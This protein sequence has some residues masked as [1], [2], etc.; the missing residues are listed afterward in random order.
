MVMRYNEPL[1]RPPAEANSLI[2]Q[3]A[4]ECPNNTCTFCGM[5]KGKKYRERDPIDTKTVETYQANIK[6]KLG[7]ENASELSRY[8]IQWVQSS[9]PNT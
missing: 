5:Y 1:Y 2:F 3:A 9:S 7:I 6:F 8:A 4:Y